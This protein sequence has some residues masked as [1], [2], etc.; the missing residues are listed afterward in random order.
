M[1]FTLR[2]G[3]RRHPTLARFSSRSDKCEQMSYWRWLLF[4]AMARLEAREDQYMRIPNAKTIGRD[5]TLNVCA[6]GER[7][8]VSARR[9][10]VIVEHRNGDAQRDSRHSPIRLAACLEP[11]TIVLDADVLDRRHALELA[12]GEIGRLHGLDP[13]PIVRALWRRE[14][15]G[16]TALGCGVAIPHARIGG[17]E[18]PMTLYMR[19]KSAI[20]FAAPDGEPVIHILII[21]V[22]SDGDTDDHLQLLAAVAQLFSDGV[23]R[24]RVAAARDSTAAAGVFADWGG[25]NCTADL[26]RSGH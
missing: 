19:P 18:C 22:P 1:A 8:A 10:A 14:T 5:V 2:L 21:L 3:E 4:A 12:A 11:Q 24:D 16:S 25:A 9:L 20:D 13:E 23:F 7:T 15:V 17:I 26:G 6:D